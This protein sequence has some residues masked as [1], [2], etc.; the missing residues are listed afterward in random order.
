ML[1]QA[2]LVTAYLWIFY[3]LYVLTMA[4]YR[5]KL[6]GRLNGFS[7]ALLY[8]FVIVAA[9]MD[10]ICNITIAALIFL[11]FPKEWLVTQRLQRYHTSDNGWRTLIAA[12]VCENLLDPFDPTGDHC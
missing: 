5:A 6:A 7:K 8:P 2:I 9:L 12:Y 11:E 1:E 10:V 4:A 3:V